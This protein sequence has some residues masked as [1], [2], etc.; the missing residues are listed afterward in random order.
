[1]ERRPRLF[2]LLDATGMAGP[3]RKVRFRPPG[4]KC[5]ILSTSADLEK[6]ALEIEPAD[7]KWK[8][9]YKAIRDKVFAHT[10]ATKTAEELFRGTLIGDI[11]DILHDLNKIRTTV[12]QLLENGRQYWIA[13]DD[14]SYADPTIAD[15][16]ALLGRL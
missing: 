1:M 6:I 12:F 7:T 16:R 3:G 13:D 5:Q 4:T 8:G 11:E 10:D 2:L 9:V 15:T 14:R